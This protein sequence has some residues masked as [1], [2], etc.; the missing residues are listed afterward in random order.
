MTPHGMVEPS[1]AGVQ[2]TATGPRAQMV[3]VAADRLTTGN[4]RGRLNG[5]EAQRRL[6]SR[7]TSALPS[8]CRAIAD[9]DRRSKSP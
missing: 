1:T 8:G 2:P 9:I 5:A 7:S 3:T 4:V 6:L